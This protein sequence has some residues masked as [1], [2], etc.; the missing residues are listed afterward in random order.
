VRWALRVWLAL[1][2][3][4]A[5]GLL[6]SSPASAHFK[7]EKSVPA[8]GA[9]VN[10]AVPEISLRFTAAG[11]PLG[12]GFTLTA[13]GGGAVPV[14]VHTP[15]GGRTWLVHPTTPLPA[16]EFTLAWRVAAPDAHPLS[17]T[18][19][20]ETLASAPGP[21]ATAGPSAT[22]GPHSHH[23]HAGPTMAP[24]AP[25]SG[26]PTHHAAE[27]D[28]GAVRFVG[29]LGR[30]LSYGAI[31]LGAGGLLFA[32][33]TLVGSRS[34]IRVVQIWVRAAGLAVMAGASLEFL[35]LAVIFSADGSFASAI[36]VATLTALARSPVSV[37]LALRITG[38]LGLLA[39]GSLEAALIRGRHAAGR[40]SVPTVAAI[41]TDTGPLPAPAGTD[42]ADND[43]Q[44]VRAGA[45]RPVLL[46]VT[47]ALLLGSFLF[48]G[49]T[50]TAGPRAAVMVADLAHTAAAAVWVGGVLLLAVLLVSR[51]RSG[52]PTGAAEMAVR[53][54]VPAAAA[55][56]VAGLAGAVLTLLILN[57]PGDLVGT[58]W[59]RILLIKIT[60]VVIVALVGFY[61]NRYVLPALDQ[62][63]TD[64]TRRLRRTVSGEAALM[65][66]VM[67]VTA[68]LVNAGT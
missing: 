51:A 31:L 2:P 35:A 68:I 67:L 56:G 57:R 33:T 19:T 6:L 37:G 42:P 55:V 54:S 7:L 50:V 59:G 9:R 14:T 8:D 27:A 18:I 49:H 41:P 15:D 61:N 53:F 24:S 65:L 60:L 44:R 38:A 32:L 36:S 47:V 39:A 5:T 4:L 29:T 46:A 22:A 48:D 23:G 28:R 45:V 40:H 21:T 1:L 30:W 63:T 64:P 11:T 13:G 17:G 58:A 10:G 62:G 25:P 34:D 20:F 26:H 12:T 66:G 3:A 43:T 52:V 16:G